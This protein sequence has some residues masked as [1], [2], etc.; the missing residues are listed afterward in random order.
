MIEVN[1]NRCIH[2]KNDWDKFEEINEELGKGE[3]ND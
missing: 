2:C 3:N 1:Y